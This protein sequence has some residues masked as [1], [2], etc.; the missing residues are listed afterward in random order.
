M[1]EKNRVSVMGFPV[2]LYTL[3]PVGS[4]L[5]KKKRRK[6]LL[7][8]ENRGKCDILTLIRIRGIRRKEDKKQKT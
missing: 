3:I 5:E 1:R 4:A 2:F 8:L 6:R 7:D